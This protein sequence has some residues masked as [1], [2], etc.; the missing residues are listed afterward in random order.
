M[1]RL[2]AT[3]ALLLALAASA[4][5]QPV[6]AAAPRQPCCYLVEVIVEACAPPRPVPTVPGGP[7]TVEPEGDACVKQLG[8][9]LEQI[10]PYP[11]TWRTSLVRDLRDMGLS[12]VIVWGPDAGVLFAGRSGATCIVGELGQGGH[13]VER[14]APNADATCGHPFGPVTN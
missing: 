1:S 3:V 11:T 14:V 9:Y 7:T 8:H 13:R 10:R 2:V 5:I 6:A 4:P 12:D